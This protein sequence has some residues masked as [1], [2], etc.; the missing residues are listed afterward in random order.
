MQGGALSLTR[1]M[2]G[3]VMKERSMKQ[4]T[5]QFCGGAGQVTGACYLL[6]AGGKN[7]LV[8][9]GMFQGGRFSEQENRQT[10]PFDPKEIDVVFV[11]HAHADH[12]GRLPKLVKDGFRGNVICTHPTAD[13]MDVMLQDA[14]TIMEHE[15]E[16]SKEEMLYSEK[17]LA[18]TLDLLTPHEYN[19]RITLNNRIDV[20]LRESAH[21]LGSS[22]VEMHI[23]D[24]IL[25]FT[26]DLGN[27]P[28]PILKSSIY[29]IEFCD[30]MVMESVYGDR[31]HNHDENKELILER[32]IEDTVTKK[33][34]VIIPVFALERTQALLSVLEELVENSR[35]PRIP[36]FL[37][38]PLAI[39]ATKVYRKYKQYFNEVTQAGAVKDFELFGFPGLTLCES[40]EQSQNINDV[41]AP[42]L[43]MAG[44]PHGYGS[45]IAHHFI[46]YLPDP[47]S[48]VVFVGYPRVSSLGRRLTEGAREVQIWEK[49]VPVRASI[50]NI[51]GYS[52][53]ADQA[54]LKDFVA[55]INKPIKN[56]FVSMGEQ[57]SSETLANVLRDD[58]GIHAEVPSFK[59]T[60]NLF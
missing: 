29:P 26:G 52:A 27:T 7:I 53:H 46:R 34:V 30:Y 22:M 23:D 3:D 55:G 37:D 33:G 44:N 32:I 49:N 13:L 31:L 25:V 19:E 48:T 41:P 47:A 1:G 42:K 20:Y 56:V 15:C 58:V 8:D 51:S 2:R 11:T 60:V 35:I 28:S 54:Q 45:R 18:Q 24:E 50:V 4:A 43:I 16:H 14:L 57:Q 21:I 40:R 36:M 17:D 5:L 9:C 10:F 12:I 59:Q 39:H 6:R 38:S